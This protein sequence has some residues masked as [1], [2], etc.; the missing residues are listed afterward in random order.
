MKIQCSN[1]LRDGILSGGS[2]MMANCTTAPLGYAKQGDRMKKNILLIFSIVISALNANAATLSPEQEIS[3]QVILR[4]VVTKQ[5]LGKNRH[6]LQQ[7]QMLE[8]L[9]NRDVKAPYTSIK[10]TNF[11]CD[12]VLN[13]KDV[14]V[15]SIQDKT[16]DQTEA[17]TD[18]T[19][20]IEKG[21]VVSA[22]SSLIAD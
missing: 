6:A 16:V 19:V 20:T 18:L 3:A 22:V 21:E 2:K 14:C 11:T 12:Y 13:G 9:I 7:T 10:I 8:D 5:L 15:I 17:L 4:Q 1:Q